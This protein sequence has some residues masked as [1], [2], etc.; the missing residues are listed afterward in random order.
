[1]VGSLRA[2]AA[3]RASRRAVLAFLVQSS[4]ALVILDPARSFLHLS[5]YYFI[6]LA[7]SILLV[8]SLCVAAAICGS[9]RAI[10]AFLV[11]SQRACCTSL[12]DPAGSF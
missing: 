8:G 10:L 3:I 11:Q 2:A 1:M 9:R 6:R 7:E 5:A 12:L 4:R